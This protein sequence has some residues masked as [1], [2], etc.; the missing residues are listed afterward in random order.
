MK[1]KLNKITYISITALTI[2]LLTIGIVFVFNLNNGTNNN[3]VDAATMIYTEFEVTDGYNYDSAN[4]KLLYGDGNPYHYSKAEAAEI[5]GKAESDITFIETGTQLYTFLN[6]GSEGKI[7]YL[8]KDVELDYSTDTRTAGISGNSTNCEFKGKLCGNA[9]TITINGGEGGVGDFFR[10][11]NGAEAIG[12][13]MGSYYK[14]Q[15][16]GY[17]CA[18]LS[19]TIKDCNIVF[20][21]KMN[22]NTL[23]SNSNVLKSQEK[24]DWQTQGGV[25]TG[26]IAPG[27]L[28]YNCFLKLDGAFVVAQA[29]GNEKSFQTNFAIAGGVV[30]GIATRGKM[31]RCTLE[32]NGGVAAVADGRPRYLP[33][34]S[35]TTMTIAGGLCGAL[36]DG[37][38]N[39]ATYDES[40]PAQI[41]YCSLKG[42]GA[43]NSKCYRARQNANY[44]AYAGGAVGG[45][46]VD[47]SPTATAGGTL[48]ANQIT[49]IMS[50]WTGPRSDNFAH[51]TKTVSGMLFDDLGDG[52]G[53]GAVNIV[54]LY[55]YLTLANST[56]NTISTL[57]SA[58]K[59]AFGSW[60]EIYAKT[61]NGKIKVSY[62]FTSDMYDI[63]IEA[64]ANGYFEN[65]YHAE[66][67]SIDDDIG[68]SP[69]KEFTMDSDYKDSP[70]GA[71]IWS[72]E[73]CQGNVHQEVTSQSIE[74]NNK[75]GAQIYRIKAT[76]N[77]GS[78]VYT[79]G[80]LVELS[81]ENTNSLEY[82]DGITDKS[83]YYNHEPINMPRLI[84]K[85]SDGETLETNE[86][87]FDWDVSLQRYVGTS[88]SSIN[89]DVSNKATTR[90]INRGQV[91]VDGV[92][93]VVEMEVADTF[94]NA[95]LFYP[96]KYT[97]K[98]TITI[99]DA[100]GS[101]ASSTTY[102]YFDQENHILGNSSV[103]S[104]TYTIMEGGTTQFKAT[105]ESEDWQKEAPVEISYLN[106]AGMFEYFTYQD[107]T[108]EESEY[109]PM[110]ASDKTIIA[111]TDRKTT[112]SDGR[113]YTIRAYLDFSL[114]GQT[115]TEKVLVG[116]TEIIVKVD[117]DAPEIENIEYFIYDENEE[118][119]IGQRINQDQLENI[120]RKDKVVI[121]Y[122]VIDNDCSGLATGIGH[123]SAV[124]SEDNQTWHCVYIMDCL[125]KTV[126][127]S[128]KVGN[129]ESYTFNAKIDTVE[130]QLKKVKTKNYVTYLTEL[131][132]YGYCSKP[133]KISYTPD[134]GDSGAVLQYAIVD[135]NNLSDVEWIDYETEMIAGE[136]NEFYMDWN[137]ID[138]H[139]WLRLVNKQ[140]LYSDSYANGDGYVT[141]G[142]SG[143]EGR[144]WTIQIIVAR[145]GISLNNLYLDSYNLKSLKD[146]GELPNL[147]VKTFNNKTDSQKATTISLKLYKEGTTELEDGIY[148]QYSDEYYESRPEILLDK[149][150]FKG[151][152]DSKNA[153]NRTLTLSADGTGYYEDKYQIYFI[154]DIDPS[155]L[156]GKYSPTSSVEEVLFSRFENLDESCKSYV[157]NTIIKPY[158][159]VLNLADEITTSYTFGEDIPTLLNYKIIEN[160]QIMDTVSLNYVTDAK[161]EKK[162]GVIVKYPDVGSYVTNVAFATD[163]GN[164]TLNVNP[165]TIVITQRAVNV[166]HYLD[167]ALRY[168]TT[169]KYTGIS[170]KITGIYVDA[171]GNNKS[172]TIKY[173]RDYET[174]SAY[175]NE[176]GNPIDSFVNVGTYYAKMSILDTNYKVANIT[177]P[178]QIKITKAFISLDLSAQEYEYTGSEIKYVAKTTDKV[179]DDFI[180]EGDFT[181]EYFRY[182]DSS[183]YDEKTHTIIEGTASGTAT[184]PID[185]GYYKVKITLAK[186]DN[187]YM[188]EYDDSLLVVTKAST[189][190]TVLEDQIIQRYTFSEE[191]ETFIYN[192]LQAGVSV[193]TKQG[194]VPTQ[195]I[196]VETT[197]NDGE[198]IKSLVYY[199]YDSLGN[200]TTNIISTDRVI[201]S[202]SI[203]VLEYSTDNLKT[204]NAVTASDGWY[205]FVGTYH[206][207]VT[208][209]G[210]N[211]FEACSEIYTIIIDKA[212]M[213][214]IVFADATANF[215]QEEHYVEV[216]KNEALK[217]YVEN[218]G[219]TYKYIYNQKE[220]AGDNPVKFV[221]V[222]E[223]RVTLEVECENFNTL[224]LLAVLSLKK[225]KMTDVS[226]QYTTAV[227]NGEYV[228]PII[229]GLDT[230]PGT[231]TL[232]KDSDGYYYYL[233]SKVAIRYDDG[234]IGY[235][236]GEYSGNIYLES[237]SYDTL[238][239]ETYIV[240]T[241]VQVKDVSFA[242]INRNI[243]S[244]TD[245]RNL[246]GVF[247]NVSSNEEKCNFVFYLEGDE[248]TPVVLRE[249]GTLPAGN[250][251][252]KVEFTD[253]NYY[254]S[255]QAKLTITNASADGNNAS[256]D[257]AGSFIKEN[258]TLIIGIAGGAVAAVVVV[259]VIITV[260]KKKKSSGPKE[261]KA[262]K[263]PKPKKEKKSKSKPND[264]NP[265]DGISQK[266][267]DEVTF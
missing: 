5:E 113:H 128:D 211:H 256:G 225:A 106:S 45:S 248:T 132:N 92:I 94:S 249:D 262:P 108:G 100:E 210:D 161:T 173:Y 120:W 265:D 174:T 242:A 220:Y 232:K 202:D 180:K 181:F 117:N 27:G 32:N 267:D 83:K 133:V 35:G 28:L 124:R 224:N 93:E 263:E 118:N 82:V 188:E 78:F 101:A 137:M 187:F 38:L 7:G 68:T 204:W 12:Y 218:F 253:G 116:E 74:P 139:L 67:G 235:N 10:D 162:D 47:A 229:F 153:G 241:P 216:T 30:G 73:L 22:P 226:T 201:P 99:S 21:S 195:I 184:T 244:K 203:V 57:D 6:A 214:G 76:G 42:K 2:V 89:D 238:V 3:A 135:P 109:K 158:E 50:A 43:V 69:K 49:G 25:V 72:L 230:E 59:M 52:S 138:K 88:F 40:N 192:V 85:N 191:G 87:A 160:E 16:T 228:L 121:T 107:M 55:D 165:A 115:S 91:N 29:A 250:Y 182:G 183:V 264:K 141:N 255:A 166:A 13:Q 90:K 215:D 231:S 254:T 217:K 260:I 64:V 212:D 234:A 80:Q 104:Y 208:F 146:N 102:T 95:N 159:I 97:F 63:R 261:P 156:I 53:S 197:I 110:T 155:V 129:I 8:T 62:D 112:P 193:K 150:E 148:M 66:K 127:Y 189:V 171:Y 257:G 163:N 125:T 140:G 105:T 119:Y 111:L 176:N 144:I 157:L 194:S 26:I 175:L 240:I 219:A 17:L 20:N 213:K 14:R 177:N 164:Y 258:L 154:D 114:N 142:A 172:A 9:Y 79:F 233:G 46:I 70:T 60:L 221:E 168:Q 84:I 143:E 170:H 34:D 23:S 227:Y 206:F 19:G 81:I 86:S 185:V 48:A 4:N 51:S 147:F 1:N 243:T 33:T 24:P 246:S 145:I 31:E 252:V 15:Y 98:P 239:L 190:M 223:Y 71:F 209:K 245:L 236:V 149:L 103:S 200:K 39:K 134:F 198:E 196:D 77:K 65:G 61:S 237:T 205:K 179:A 152:F 58:G 266:D 44:Y 136:P 199:T 222:G 123:T 96:G 247:T 186:S 131:G 122:D 207:R 178:I 54:V 37:T 36:K 126:Q 41:K 151:E 11:S 130:T 56:G 169:L 167:D 251:I 18:V 75:I 259:V